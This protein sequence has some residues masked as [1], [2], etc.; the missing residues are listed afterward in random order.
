MSRVIK[1]NFLIS[2]YKTGF[3]FQRTG[4]GT[5]GVLF[6]LT[7]TRTN[8]KLEF[9]VRRPRLHLQF[10]EKRDRIPQTKGRLIFLRYTQ[11][12]KELVSFFFI[13]II[14]YNR[15]FFKHTTGLDVSK[16]IV[17][18]SKKVSNFLFLTF[19][20]EMTCS[21]DLKEMD[22]LNY[23]TLQTRACYQ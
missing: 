8:N 23:S 22:V 19:L 15:R 13:I 16:Q 21:S 12:R 6:Q 3:L 2:A 5:H 14:F 18:I 10:A 7:K 20:C 9:A 11:I 17:S 4:N 1:R